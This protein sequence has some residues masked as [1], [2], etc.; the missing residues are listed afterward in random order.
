LEHAVSVV[1]DLV[2]ITG[3]A[4]PVHQARQGVPDA[5]LP[6]RALTVTPMGKFLG[7]RNVEVFQEPTY[8]ERWHQ[9]SREHFAPGQA[10]EIQVEIR[11]PEAYP[12]AAAVQSVPAELGA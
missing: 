2:E 1:L 6:T 4:A 8:V 7:A 3:S 10:I 12:V 5:W 11:R 9:V